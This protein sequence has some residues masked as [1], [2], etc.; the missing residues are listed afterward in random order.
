MLCCE[1][2]LTVDA[3]HR[4]RVSTTETRSAFRGS[5]PAMNAAKD[6]LVE[7][8]AMK[9]LEEAF[10]WATRRTPRFLRG[11]VAIQDEYTHDC[12]SGGFA[13]ALQSP[14]RYLKRV[15]PR[16][17]A[18]TSAFSRSMPWRLSSTF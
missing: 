14:K 4:M 3:S 5:I 2:P 11:D 8:E 15:N 17:I 6:A 9:T 13:A 16:G 12:E 10:R 7:A 18:L 1:L